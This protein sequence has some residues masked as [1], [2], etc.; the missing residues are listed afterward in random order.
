MT[1]GDSYP[2]FR[3]TVYQTAGCCY[4]LNGFLHPAYY[5]SLVA[6]DPKNNLCE[7]EKELGPVA[8]AFHRGARARRLCL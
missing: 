1:I 5:T 6:E 7:R 8:S 2:P 4:R 3:P